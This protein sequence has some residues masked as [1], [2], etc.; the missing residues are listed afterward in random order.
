MKINLPV[1]GR[2]VE[3]SA[4]ANILSTTDPKGAITYVNPDFINISG[5]SESELL[6]VNHNIVRHP[7]MPPEAFAHLWQ[8]LK[9]G[10]SWM[11]LVKNRCKNGDHYWVSAYVTPMQR[12]GETVE[13]QSVR[14]LPAKALVDV[15]EQ[16]YTQ[17]RSG[18]KARCLRLSRLPVGM[19]L[20]LL[21]SGINLLGFTALVLLGALPWGHAALG[22]LLLS[23]SLGAVLRYNLR[24]LD[25]LARKA[26]NI[27]DNPLSQI[28]YSGRRDQFGQVD[29]ALQMLEAET[30]A[31]VG[32][33][34]DSSRQLSQEA[35]ALVAAVD[36]NNDAALRQQ[37]DTAQVASAVSQMASSVQEV[38]RN[39]QL[40][41]SAANLANQ[42][43]DRGQQ[44]VEQTRQ[45]ID[46]LAS[47]VQQTSAVIHQLEQH[48]NEIDRVL[49]VIQ[50]IAEQTNLLAL[51]AAIEA[52]RAGEAGRG[53]A[54]VADEVRGLASRTQQSTAH[55]QGTIDTLRRSTGDAVLAMQRSHS[56]AEVSVEQAQLAA[57]AL[58]GITQRVDEISGMSVQIAA[59]VEQQ[60]AVGD[61]IQCSLADISQTTH[62][63]VQ[64]SSQS[65]STAAH[66]ASQAERL[67]LLSAQLWGRQCS[68]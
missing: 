57:R 56:Q 19:R 45:H 8:T 31:I 12:N 46:S 41:A 38:A 62:K 5:F 14:T 23:V 52:A 11:G 36:S 51:N 44:L 26:A 66:V 21:G 42:A 15:A 29:F 54:V 40:T 63:S 37:G 20:A 16:L 22:T 43:S 13:Y 64:A 32:R 25:A 28:L 4:N 48:G 35:E 55:I 33:I 2:A 59:A 39:A 47:E 3:F 30:R 68:E 50:S 65:R 27:A 49:E 34:A 7:D 53:F 61:S 17:L 18:K 10:R 24:P 67:Q 58:D 6:G 9:A 60:S 1:S